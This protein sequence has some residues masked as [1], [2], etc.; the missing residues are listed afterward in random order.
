MLKAGV[1][2]FVFSSSATV[3]GAPDT[4]QYTEDLPTSPINIQPKQTNGRKIIGDISRANPSFKAAFLCY[5]NPVGAHPSGLIGGI[6]LA[7]L[8]I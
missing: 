5:F 6:L 4:P 1:Y 3:C 8:I 7:H 2:K